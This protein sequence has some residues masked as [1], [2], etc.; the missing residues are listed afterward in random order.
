MRGRKEQIENISK[1]RPD[2]SSAL[3]YGVIER[4]DVTVTELR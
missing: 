2:L 3:A 4:L 1:G